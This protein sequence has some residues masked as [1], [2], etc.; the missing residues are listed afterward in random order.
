MALLNL[1]TRFLVTWSKFLTCTLAL[2]VAFFWSSPSL[3]PS[4]LHEPTE[5]RMMTKTAFQAARLTH[6]TFLVQEYNDIFS[7]H[8]HIYVKLF[9]SAKAMLL[10]DTGTGGKS[11]DPD[12]EVTSL[13]KFL[14]TIDVADN[15]NKPLNE[16]GK[17]KYVVVTTHCH[18]DHIC[19]P[20]KRK[21]R[22][23]CGLIYD[24]DSG[25]RRL[26]SPERKNAKYTMPN[27]GK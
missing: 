11:N 13:R 24:H 20:F 10:I 16:G 18:Y 17:M 7:E 19:T 5:H 22:F 3:F 4:R 6:S 14:E 1:S 9:P 23:D 8:P 2:T 26:V 27:P 25:R 21:F 15:E 12:V